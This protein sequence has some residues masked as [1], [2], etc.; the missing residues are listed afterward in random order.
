MGRT[1][2]AAQANG[3]ARKST[4]DD[5]VGGAA[6]ER[7]VG[8]NPT[9]TTNCCEW[10]YLNTTNSEHVSN[11]QWRGQQRARTSPGKSKPTVTLPGPAYLLMQQRFCFLN[12]QHTN[13]TPTGHVRQRESGTRPGSSRRSSWSTS[14][15]PLQHQNENREHITKPKVQM[16]TVH[17]LERT[18]LRQHLLGAVCAGHISSPPIRTQT[19]QNDFD[20]RERRTMENFGVQAP[21]GGARLKSGGTFAL[22]ALFEV[23]CGVL[24]QRTAFGLFTSSWNVT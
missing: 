10:Q 17:P 14:P 13:R 11:G 22:V 8:E 12:S 16:R 15:S 23:F 4:R 6:H 21:R 19:L 18:G 5:G 9:T 1:F 7:V 24:K 2:T 20:M 3:A